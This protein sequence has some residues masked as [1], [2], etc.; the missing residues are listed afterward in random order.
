MN[1]CYTRLELLLLKSVTSFLFHRRA[2]WGNCVNG[3]TTTLPFD[4]ALGRRVIIN[5]PYYNMCFLPPDGSPEWPELPKKPSISLFKGINEYFAGIN[6]PDRSQESKRRSG[7]WLHG[8]ENGTMQFNDPAYFSFLNGPSENLLNQCLRAAFPGNESCINQRAFQLSFSAIFS[9]PSPV[10]KDALT[11]IRSRLALPELSLG[12]ESQPGAWGLRTP[13]YYILGLH[14]R[15]FPQGFEGFTNNADVWRAGKHFAPFMEASEI[16]AKHAKEIVE[17]RGLQL[18]IYF[19]TDHARALRSTVEQ[20]LSQYGRVMFGLEEKEVGHVIPM[21]T[22]EDKQ[23]LEKKK[24]ACK[25]NEEHPGFNS[26][27]YG[28]CHFMAVP[29]ESNEERKLHQIMGMA[30]WWILAQSHWLVSAGS[31]YSGTAANVGLGPM[32]V[33]ERFDQLDHFENGSGT[34]F[35]LQHVRRDLEGKDPC[36]PIFAADPLEALKCPNHG[37]RSG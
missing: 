9:R 5:I 29:S 27:N 18:L 26:S 19:A 6:G 12:V 14:F 33:M 21:F 23:I 11:T 20:H 3:L 28:S 37:H 10:L 35:M 15:S 7:E 4:V 32:G 1:V 34:K 36:K 30:E 24:Q 22:K 25:K 2:G 16:I 13:G 17:C 31:T 8:L